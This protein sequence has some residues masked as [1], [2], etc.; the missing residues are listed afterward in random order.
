[1]TK[2]AFPI[3]LK[4]FRWMGPE[5][6][7]LVILAP[8]FAASE[9]DTN[10]L[11]LQQS[12]ILALLK[13]QPELDILILSFQ[14]PYEV[15]TYRW[16][17]AT[18]MSFGGRNKGGIKRLLLRKKINTVLEKIQSEKNIVGLLSFWL[19]EGALVGKRFGDKYGIKHFTWLLGQ[20]ARSTNKYPKRVGPGEKELIAL[21][22][23]VQ[24]EYQRNHGIKPAYV[25][26]P[27]IAEDQ[28]P[29]FAKEKDIDLLAV[30]SLI[31]L[32]QYAIFI[33]VV[34]E[35]KKELPQ[36]KAVLTGDGPEKG[37]LEEKIVQLG[38]QNTITLTGELPNPEVLKLMQ[39]AKIFLHSSS[40]EGF[41]CV[42]LEALYGGAKVISF[43]QPVKK[44]IENW[45]IVASKKE[46]E[47][48]AIGILRNPDTKYE[49]GNV[50]KIEDTAGKMLDLFGL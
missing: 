6:K 37:M 44:E 3:A 9:A 39:R 42:C 14:F 25:I 46:M 41:G 32:K 33:D 22:D 31:P 8:G 13:L 21:S 29:F 1:M 45:F 17:G 38:L 11:P 36:I 16:Y 50:F 23:F 34:A 43:V 7:T 35:I 2:K 4:R 20:D 15:S 19:N 30:G 40:Y 10:C 47:E 18:V 27:G 12:L 26:E 49:R 28:F 24:E 48:K 5:K